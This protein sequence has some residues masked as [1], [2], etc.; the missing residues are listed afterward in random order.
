MKNRL[1]RNR[2]VNSENW[3]QKSAGAR[4]SLGRMSQVRLTSFSL[5][6]KFKKKKKR[7][8][9]FNRAFVRVTADAHSGKFLRES[10]LLNA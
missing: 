10:D 5:K 3:R 7:S 2:F 9:G 6:Q 8:S 1:L 4:M